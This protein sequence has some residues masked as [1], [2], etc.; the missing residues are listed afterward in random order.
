MLGQVTLFLDMDG[1]LT[2]FEKAYREMW[3]EFEYDRERF[4]EAVISRRIFQN[5]EWMPNGRHFLD[6]IESIADD[7]KLDVQML[8]STGSHRT[9][10]KEAAIEQKTIWLGNNGI[11][12]M[13]NFV[14]SKPEKSD[15]AHKR[16]ILIDD[17]I[18]CITP[19]I[20]RGGIGLLHNDDDYKATTQKL[21][22]CLDELT[23]VFI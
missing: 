14:C 20:E 6:E 21:R 4:R 2:N 22:W 17:S 16:A 5:L 9:E 3:N 15:Y 7:Y 8:T 12:W 18:G 19:F 10:M 11:P 1:V 13:P 23:K